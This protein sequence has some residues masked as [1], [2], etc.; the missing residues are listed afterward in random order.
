MTFLSFAIT[1][2]DGHY[3]DAALKERFRIALLRADQEWDQVQARAG[4][5]RRDS[6]RDRFRQRLD[7]LLASEVY[8]HVDG[9]TKERLL[10]EVTELAFP[11][12]GRER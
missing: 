12:K 1:A 10:S 4:D 2:E 11:P 5:K 9:V 6:R 3:H 7:T 8:R